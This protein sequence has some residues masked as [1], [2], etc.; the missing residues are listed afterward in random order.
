MSLLLEGLKVV[1]AASYLAAP[2]AATVM[3]DYGADVVKIEPPQGD[4]FRL[5]HGVHRTDYNWQLTSR[6]KRDICL[7]LNHASAREVLHRLVDDADVL[8]VNFSEDQ[9]TRFEL[10]YEELKKTNPRLV[11]A[12]LTGFGDVGPDRKRRGFDA[13]TWWAR[14]GILE[15]MAPF[16]QSPVYPPGGVGDHATSMSLLSAIMMA[17]YHRERSGEGR[18]VSTSLVASGCYANG[19]QLQ[20]AIAGFDLSTTLKKRQGQRGPFAS[21][22]ETRDEQFVILAITNPQKEWPFLA[23]CLGHP[24]W[25]LDER[26]ADLPAIMRHRTE[27]RE[28]VAG[29]MKSMR[30]A[31]LCLALEEKNLP[32]APVEALGD[33]VDDAHLI[34]NEVFVKT[35]SEDED[36][37]WAVAN[38]IKVHGESQRPP[39]D[40]PQIGQH[41]R[42][43]LEEIGYSVEQINELLALGVA[44]VA[45]A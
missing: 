45:D 17:L 28:V 20:G 3:S 21:V 5:L 25:L 13:T 26:F 33:V 8:L 24:E 15:M 1:D 32:Y 14:S 34:E 35:D 42:E 10:E 29:V 30:L 4:G 39:S 38:P 22:Y 16:D 41:T 43:I 37:Q 44:R 7:D 9:L 19:M 12:R 18:M 40:A 23:E 6:N 2:A 31:D 27:L 11:Y 36:Y